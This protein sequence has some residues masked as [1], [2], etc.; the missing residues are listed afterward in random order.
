MTELLT[1]DDNNRD[2]GVVDEICNY[3]TELPPRSFFL[4]AGAGSGKTRTLVEVLRRLTGVIEHAK[5]GELARR[6]RMYGRSIRV[7]TYTKNAVSVINGRLGDNDLVCVSTIHS[8]CW[9]L[10]SGFHDDIREAL[11]ALKTTQLAKETAEAQ[12]KP[13]GITSAKQRDLDKISSDIDELRATDVFIYHPDR[14]TYGPGA[15][16]HNNVLDATAWLLQNKPTLQT[17]LKDRHPIV[18][19]DE[20]QD[21]M[22]G[23][24]DVLIELAEQEKKYFTLGL[25]GDHRQRIYMD[26]HADLPSLVPQTWATPELQMNHRSQRRIV[27]LINKIWKAEL[28]GR[29]QPANGV[30]QHSRTEKAGGIVRIFIGDTSRLPEDKVLGESWCAEQMFQASSSTAWELNQY[31]LLALEHKLV[32]TRGLFLDVYEAMS[33]LDPN[34]AAPSGTGENKGPSV[35]QIILNELVELETCIGIDGSVN[36]FKATEILRRYGC[37]DNMPEDSVARTCRT[38][39]I[40]KAVTKFAVACANPSSTVADVLEPILSA[41]LFEIAPCLLE[42]YADKSPAPSA[43]GRREE[44]SKQTRM[45]RGWCAL[46]TAPW[47]QLKRYNGYLSGQSDLATHQVVKGSEFMHV[48]VVMDDKLAGGFL[49][50]YDK[51]FGGEELSQRDRDNVE[52]GKETTIDRSLR[53][54]Y[55]TCSRAQ[56]SLALVLWSSDPVAALARIKQSSWFTEDEIQVIPSSFSPIL[57]GTDAG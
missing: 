30:M 15:L 31:K 5:G 43:P 22:K 34:A 28:E 46:F 35:A 18:L 54:L 13:R 6:L 38:D 53:L 41:S 10:I 33:L 40:L 29:T 7:V 51:I 47:S 14:N 11:I 9:E 1:I 42:A 23:V 19:I 25:L 20:S 16:A 49:I 45:R 32:A 4:F 24:L 44:E 48:M 36:E 50:S 37:L 27:T 17:I 39:S 12:Q 26:G 2:V 8:F 3:L 55:V 52:M 21:T 57:V 56:E